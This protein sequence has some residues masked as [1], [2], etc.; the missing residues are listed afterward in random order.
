MYATLYCQGCIWE[1]EMTGLCLQD[2]HFSSEQSYAL[3]LVRFV[4]FTAVLDFPI[5]FYNSALLL[6]HTIMS[7]HLIFQML[8]Y[9]WHRSYSWDNP[10]TGHIQFV[11]IADHF[12]NIGF[13][14]FYQFVRL[15][16]FP[17]L[18]F[19][20]TELVKSKSRLYV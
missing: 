6:D 19:P 7:Y 10:N 11:S 12:R 18:K 1:K 4:P 17:W 13:N 2:A 9:C 20:K 3:F 5:F 8:N 15:L 16:I 14:D